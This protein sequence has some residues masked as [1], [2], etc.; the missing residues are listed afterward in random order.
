[1]ETFLP[2][3]EQEKKAREFEVL[4]QGERTVM[5]YR[6]EETYLKERIEEAKEFFK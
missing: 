4:K 3:G 6:N 2:R 5:D 1:M